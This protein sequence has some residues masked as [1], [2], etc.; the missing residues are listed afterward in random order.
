[1]DDGY[2][3][4]MGQLEWTYVFPKFV[5]LLWKTLHDLNDDLQ[6]KHGDVSIVMSVY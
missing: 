2:E 3:K 1:L 6:I 4:I 5:G